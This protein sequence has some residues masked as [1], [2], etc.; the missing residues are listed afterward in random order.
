MY[1]ILQ[2]ASKNMYKSRSNNEANCHN[3]AKHNCRTQKMQN[4]HGYDLSTSQWWKIGLW[5][6]ELWHSLILYVV[7]N[8]LEET[9]ILTTAEAC[10]S[11]IPATRVS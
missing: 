7:T 6:S 1:N 5:S 3:K 11:K 10:S 9:A 2:T 8:N 4:M